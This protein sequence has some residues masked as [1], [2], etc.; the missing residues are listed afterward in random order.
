M[1]LTELQHFEDMEARLRAWDWLAALKADERSIP[2]LAR[3]T[4]KSQR[5]IYAYSYGQATP[6][7]AWLRDAYRVL[8]GR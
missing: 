2:W 3:K 7:L 1:D 8:H 6:S 5:S 4:G